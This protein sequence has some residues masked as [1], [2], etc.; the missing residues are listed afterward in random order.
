MTFKIML[1]DDDTANLR[2]LERLFNRDHQVLTATS[3]PEALAL[4]EQHDVA[5][6]ITDQRI[7]GMTGIELLKQTASLRP[8]MGTPTPRSWSKPS[9]AVRSIAI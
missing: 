9:T 1:V 8:H 7:P 5:L 2:L 4:L 3:G 6:L